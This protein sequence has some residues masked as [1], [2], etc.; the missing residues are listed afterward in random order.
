[1]ANELSIIISLECK[2]ID[3][4][5]LLD[6]GVM[7]RRDQ[8]G[9]HVYSN[10]Q[11][12]GFAAEEAV[13]ISADVVTPRWCKLT[14]MDVTNFCDIGTKPSGTFIPFM[15]LQPGDQAGFPIGSAV[16]LYAK[17]NVASTRLRVSVAE[18]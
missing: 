18:A 11:D 16:A 17:S 9:S 1:M 15:R 12:I 3:G 6:K 7:F 2:T 13:S 8:A 10:V 14:N 5:Q 4:A